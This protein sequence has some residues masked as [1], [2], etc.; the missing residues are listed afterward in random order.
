MNL[1]VGGATALLLKFWQGRNQRASREERA[2]SFAMLFSADGAGAFDET[3]LALCEA[4]YKLDENPSNADYGGMAQQ[5]RVRSAAGRLLSQLLA[6]AG[7]ITVFVGQDIL[8]SLHEAIAI[9]KHHDLQAAFGVRDVWS[10]IERIDRLSHAPHR[11]AHL[12]V[13]RGKAG[14]TVLSWLA[15]AA[16]YL[17]Q[18][19]VLVK[20]DHPVIPAA[21]DWMQAALAIG[22]SGAAEAAPAMA[23]AMAPATAPNSPWSAL[24][25]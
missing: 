2:H 13:Q 6:N 23:P 16:P 1:D 14:M 15:D 22:E 25:A 18:S 11:E 12:Y 21:V 4:L 19:G 5:T 7:G 9:L 3:M 17:E 8:Q 24:A 10:V 20:L